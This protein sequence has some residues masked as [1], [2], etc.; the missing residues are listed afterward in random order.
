M[1]AVLSCS[2]VD[3]CCHFV[4]PFGWLVLFP[5]VLWMVPVFF[6]ACSERLCNW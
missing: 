1:V 4:E 6:L 2:L 3:D 5:G